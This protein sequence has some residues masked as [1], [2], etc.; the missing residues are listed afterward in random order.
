M[1]TSNNDNNI[2]KDLMISGAT[3]V[4]FNDVAGATLGDLSKPGALYDSR[5]PA[6]ASTGGTWRAGETV[7]VTGYGWP[8]G[9]TVAVQIVS[10]DGLTVLWSGNVTT[11]ASGNIPA[12]PTWLVPQNV[13]GVYRI[14]A[15]YPVGATY[16]QYDT[17]T[18]VGP[19]VTAAKVADKPS[20]ER[21]EVITYTI[22]YGNSGN[23]A[24]PNFSITDPIPAN[25]TFVG[26][27]SS[28]PGTTITYQHVAGGPFDT[29]SAAPV[30]AVRW[31]RTSLAANTTNLTATL[32]VRVNATAPDAAGRHQHG[33]RIGGQRAGVHAHRQHH[34]SGAR[35]SRQR[36]PRI[37]R[38]PPP[39]MWS[40]IR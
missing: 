10:P 22:T 17:F 29:S 7:L 6:P 19:T 26:A 36:S 23:D 38:A 8:P 4:N 3:G 37:K 15:A 34:R 30:V 2:N 20:A 11:D 35:S 25:T 14:Y 18:V 16:R 21:G 12:T 40:P 39:T 27:S 28:D 1:G 32:Q 13:S 5:D 24:A 33:D 9:G 31:T